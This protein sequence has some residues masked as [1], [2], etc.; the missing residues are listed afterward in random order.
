MSNSKY[1]EL[2]LQCHR[3]MRENLR[4]YD[5]HCREA[6]IKDRMLSSHGGTTVGHESRDAF[7]PVTGFICTRKS[8]LYITS[9]M[10][11][12][13]KLNIPG[14]HARKVNVVCWGRM[15][16]AGIQLLLLQ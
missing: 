14:G 3:L 9:S 10:H 5:S 2:L 16:S 13:S 8:H 4:G 12:Y 7:T 1:A 11:M 6:I 15:F